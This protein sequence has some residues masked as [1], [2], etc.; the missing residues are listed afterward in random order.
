LSMYIGDTNIIIRLFTKD[1]D[2]QVNTL[3]ELVDTG[4]VTLFISTIVVIESCWVLKS[5]Y[6]LSNKEIG[7]A[8]LD[9]FDSENVQLAEPSIK[10]VI[11]VFSQYSIDVVD[12]YLAEKSKSI[13][14]P[15][16]TW[17]SKDFR[18][19]NCEFYKPEELLKF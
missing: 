11:E 13:N 8:F 3:V 2:E 12:V 16:L 15:V 10:E 9:L 4:N 7:Q 14:M 6:K 18:K 19:L 5:A 1:D 17:N